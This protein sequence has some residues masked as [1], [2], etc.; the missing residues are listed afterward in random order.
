MRSG[1]PA[2]AAA[3]SGRR[4]AERSELDARRPAE[5]APS[6]SLSL[7]LTRGA[8]RWTVELS[9]LRSGSLLVDADLPGPGGLVHAAVALEG[10]RGSPGPV[11]CSATRPA[12]ARSRSPP[13]STPTTGP[14]GRCPPGGAGTSSSW[15]RSMACPAEARSTSASSI[16]RCGSTGVSSPRPRSQTR[17]RPAWPG[18]RGGAGVGG[19]GNETKVLPAPVAPLSPPAP[20]GQPGAHRCPPRRH[21]RTGSRPARSLDALAGEFRGCERAPDLARAGELRTR[22][23][24][25]DHARSGGQCAGAPAGSAAGEH[26]SGGSAARNAGAR[27]LRPAQPLPTTPAPASVPGPAHGRTSAPGPTWF[28]ARLPPTPVP[29]APM[30]ESDLTRFARSRLEN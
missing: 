21:P 5:G 29:D 19:S 13:G 3:T 17:R 18:A 23:D 7:H 6:A 10:R 8:E 28:P 4:S 12:S 24:A 14:S 9:T 16:P 22:D 30:R 1:P 27:E 2:P 11:R 15:S 25:A 20:S 26:G